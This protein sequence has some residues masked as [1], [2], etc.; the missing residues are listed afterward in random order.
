[1]ASISVLGGGISGVTTAVMLRLLGHGVTIY[2]DRRTDR[3]YGSHDPMTASLY[4]AASVIPHAVTVDN[5]AD[6]LADT[7]AFF[8]VL[9]HAKDFGVRRQLHF[10]VFEA[11][12]PDP[13]YA[14]ALID[15]RRLADSPLCPPSR[16]GAGPLHGW[17]FQVYFA[18]TPV[19]L[20]RLFR[21]FDGLG[22]RIV[23]RTVTPDTLADIPGEVLVNALGGA[24]PTL[25][26]DER[27]A[28][29]IRGILVLVPSTGLPRHRDTGQHLSYN[30]TPSSTAY[31]Q[32][33]G[34][35]A[36]VYAY[37]R[38]DVWVLGGTKQDGHLDRDG[39]WVGE[40]LVGETVDLPVPGA[41][42]GRIPVPRPILDMNREILVDL[43]GEAPDM[44]DAHAV[45]GYRY[46]RDPDGDGVRLGTGRSPDGRLVAHN[47]GHGGAGVTLSW[48]SALRVARAL[49]TAGVPMNGATPAGGGM[50][51][52]TEAP[53]RLVRRLRE[54]AGDRIMASTT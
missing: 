46:A 34:S 33:D 42:D 28:S 47:T 13:D 29:Y 48:S 11:P 12:E 9:R 40:P 4:P 37:P 8:E 24:A 26:P 31:A 15:Y 6:H 22:G 43:T 23:R 7:Q 52:M 14:P 16:R 54:V 17:H 44:S 1:M 30:Y 32:A 2:T 53:V 25:F 20:R 39:R 36:G 35:P 19:Y 5:P 50:D 21:L 3:A 49:Q 27:P 10:E 38:R 51:A 45:F 18:E 41:D